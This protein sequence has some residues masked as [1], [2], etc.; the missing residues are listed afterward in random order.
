M[1]LP[2]GEYPSLLRKCYLV[3]VRVR[4]GLDNTTEIGM[5]SIVSIVFC[6]SADRTN[7]KKYGLALSLVS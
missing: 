2:E 3:S 7:T 6:E 4:I 5:V 1:K